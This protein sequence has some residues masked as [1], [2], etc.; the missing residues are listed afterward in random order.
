MKSLIFVFIILIIYSPFIR[1][2][3]SNQLSTYN[4]DQELLSDSILVK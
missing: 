3:P 1:G 2:Q 4:Q